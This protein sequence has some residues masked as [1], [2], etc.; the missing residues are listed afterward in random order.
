M[1]EEGFSRP[2]VGV[3]DI[4]ETSVPINQTARSNFDVHRA[5]HRNIISIVKPTGETGGKETIGET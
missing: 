1:Y 3:T 2:K 5:V 4:T